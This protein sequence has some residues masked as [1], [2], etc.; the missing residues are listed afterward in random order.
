MDAVGRRAVAGLRATNDDPGSG[1]RK[2]TLCR[3]DARNRIGRQGGGWL[4]ALD[5]LGR[6]HP[7]ATGQ[8][9]LLRFAFARIGLGCVG[10]GDLPV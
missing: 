6:K 10:D 7:I 5:L 8:A 1:R 9:S 3:G 4:I 2:K